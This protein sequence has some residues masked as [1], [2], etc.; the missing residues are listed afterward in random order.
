MA[1]QHG[2]GVERDGTE[3]IA[4]HVF[5]A[6]SEHRFDTETMDVMEAAAKLRMLGKSFFHDD[7]MNQ[8]RRDQRDDY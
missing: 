1:I 6:V 4:D 8:I 2:S 3:N 7:F 5:E